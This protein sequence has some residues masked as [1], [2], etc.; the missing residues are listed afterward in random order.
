M[1]TV[2]WLTILTMVFLFAGLPAQAADQNQT[3]KIAIWEDVNTFD[4]GW[5][6]SAE[7]ELAIMTCIFNGL[8][9]YNPGNW[10]VVPSLAE[11]WEISDDGKQI[12]F[13]LRQGVQFHRGYGEMTAEDVKFSFERIADPKQKSP[14]KS[15]WEKLDKV[16]VVDKYTVKLILKEPMVNLFDSVLPLNTGMIVS[17]KAAEEMGREKFAFSPVGTGPY[18]MSSWSPKRQIALA[19]NKDY[20]GPKPKTENLV[21]IPI[22]EDSTSETALKTGEIDVGRAA[23]VNIAVFKKKKKFKVYSKPALKTYWLGMTVSK[24]PFDNLKLRQ[25]FRLAV[26][27]PKVV[28]AAFFGAAEPAAA[29]LPPGVPGRWNEAQVYKQDVPAARKLMAEGGKPDGFQMVLWVPASDTEKI[30]AEVIK[31]EAAKAGIEVII[32]AKEI[33]A[34]NEGINKGQADAYIQFY[35]STIDP[36]YIMRWFAGEDWNPSQWRNAKYVELIKQGTS[37]LDPEKREQNYIEAQKLID[38][39]AWA[40]WLTHGSRVWVAQANVDMGGLY[41]NGRLAPWTMSLK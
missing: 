18:V 15:A 21:F 30:M 25:A 39:D 40:V 20:W 14:E 32:E 9:T 6:T 38:Q 19:A 10:E 41:P 7:R 37:V 34:F 2:K 31:A 29:I 22:V 27:V 8:V 23:T 33:G 17:K 3:L 13:K 35:T 24:P 4:P 28:L 12:T 36:D 26:D 11:S 16:E 5:L 1:K